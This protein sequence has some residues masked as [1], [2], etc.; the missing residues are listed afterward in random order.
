VGLCFYSKLNK[1][2]LCISTT[3]ATSQELLIRQIKIFH[4]FSVKLVFILV[5]IMTVL[6]SLFNGVMLNSSYD[7]SGIGGVDHG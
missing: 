4:S 1:K 7:G 5:L 2:L 6:T 3:D